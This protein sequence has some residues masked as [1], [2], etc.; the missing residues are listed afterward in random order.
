LNAKIPGTRKRISSLG[1]PAYAILY[2]LI[3]EFIDEVNV[4]H[5]GCFYLEPT[6]YPPTMSLVEE[7]KDASTDARSDEAVRRAEEALK[8]LDKV[9]ATAVQRY[10]AERGWNNVSLAEKVGVQEHALAKGCCLL[11]EQTGYGA[12]DSD[13]GDTLMEE[14]R[15]IMTRW[16]NEVIIHFIGILSSLT[17]PASTRTSS[18]IEVDCVTLHL[19]F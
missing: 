2:N 4:H 12:E 1:R 7:A 13:T 3:D 17:A 6:L 19:Y 10:K 5:D 16:K 8:A 14:T 9:M 15:G 11:S 18:L